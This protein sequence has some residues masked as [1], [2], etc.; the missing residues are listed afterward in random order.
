MIYKINPLQH[1]SKYTPNVFSNNFIALNS[2]SQGILILNNS[3]YMILRQYSNNA[4]VSDTLSCTSITVINR[5]IVRK[6]Y[7]LEKKGALKG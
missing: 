6:R 5:L 3:Q 1:S 7:L 4:Y 2:Y